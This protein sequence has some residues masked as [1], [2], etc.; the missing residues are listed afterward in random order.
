M[1]LKTKNLNVKRENIF[2]TLSHKET[3]REKKL[4]NRMLQTKAF[5]TQ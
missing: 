1:T 2:I 4:D 3:E 5:L